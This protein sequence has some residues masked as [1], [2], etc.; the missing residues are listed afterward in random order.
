MTIKIRKLIAVAFIG[1]TTTVYAGYGYKCVD[2]DPPTPPETSTTATC[3]YTTTTCKDCQD[4]IL[5]NCGPWVTC[6]KTTYTATGTKRTG[7]GY[8]C[9]S[10]T[11][12]RPQNS[13]GCS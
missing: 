13:L 2:P 8:D 7:A 3:S 6:T 1:L 5:G 9:G 11:A 12:G 10:Y 4:A